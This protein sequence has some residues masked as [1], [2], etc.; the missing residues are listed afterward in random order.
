MLVTNTCLPALCWV[1]AA[2]AHHAERNCHG[3]MPGALL[4]A[5]LRIESNC[6]ASAFPAS[7]CTSSNCG[8]AGE[9]AALP[10]LEIVF[11][12]SLDRPVK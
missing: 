12:Q 6:P 7:L 2:P 5:N 1:C 8:V 3:M 9:V 10:P 4:D 11:T